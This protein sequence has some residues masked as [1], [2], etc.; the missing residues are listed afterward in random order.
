MTQ[1]HQFCA[2][3]LKSILWLGAVLLI[4]ISTST[5][6]QPVKDVKKWLK[7][8]KGQLKQAD[9][10]TAF[11]NVEATRFNLP[12]NTVV[13]DIDQKQLALAYYSIDDDNFEVKYQ[14]IVR[15]NRQRLRQLLNRAVEI[16]LIN[17][18]APSEHH[19]L[20]INT[21]KQHI[22]SKHHIGR[23]KL[24]LLFAKQESKLNFKYTFR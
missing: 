13:V 3:A 12:A 20:Y 19:R 6:A 5:W 2:Q 10:T 8:F 24:K 16:N 23:M 18:R 21:V 15:T 7:E 9:T 17:A 1:L 22:V 4:L 14:Q 11:A